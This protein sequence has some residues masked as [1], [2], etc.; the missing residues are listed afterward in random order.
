MNPQL[1]DLTNVP[2]IPLALSLLIVFF[3]L[4]GSLFVFIGAAGFVFFRNFYDRLHMPALGTSL[5]MIAVLIG[6][7]IYISYIEEKPVLHGILIIVFISIAAPISLMMLAR[8]AALR[9][10]SNNW[11][12]SSHS[13]FQHMITDKTDA[14]VEKEMVK[15]EQRQQ[16]S[17]AAAAPAIS[18]QVEQK[19]RSDKQKN[20]AATKSSRKKRTDADKKL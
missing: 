17:A 3:L 14:E 16:K 4:C 19:K 11:R 20:S 18:R 1:P 8:A 10:V 6:I 13:L 9:D 2:Q 12:D 15:E 5:G 7:S